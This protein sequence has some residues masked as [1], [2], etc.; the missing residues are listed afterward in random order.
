MLGRGE[1]QANRE[2][3]SLPIAVAAALLLVMCATTPPLPDVDE[4]LR[5]NEFSSTQSLSGVTLS[6]RP[7]LDGSELER[8]Y[9][10][11]L[12]SQGVLPIVVSV[13]NQTEE[14]LLLRR[15]DFSLSREQTKAAPSIPSDAPGWTGPAKAGTAAAGIATIPFAPLGIVP[16]VIVMNVIERRVDRAK[17]NTIQIIASEFADGTLFP[18]QERRGVLF[19]PVGEGG[20]GPETSLNLRIG[21]PLDNVGSFSV[22]VPLEHR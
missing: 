7:L 20:L 8:W 14:V 19:F 6:V 2:R 15:E 10:F 21:D 5:S 16:A 3:G 12:R 4:L 11:D 1:G 18:G 13:R 17:R 22:S 9:G